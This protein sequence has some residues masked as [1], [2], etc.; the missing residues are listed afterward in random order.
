MV[1]VGEGWWPWLNIVKVNSDLK[2]TCFIFNK[3]HDLSRTITKVILLPKPN[4]TAVWCH[5]LGLY[6]PTIHPER[7]P[8]KTVEKNLLDV[9]YK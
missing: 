7:L 2:T 9:D 1:K 6:T 3:S 5:S 4:H 8:M